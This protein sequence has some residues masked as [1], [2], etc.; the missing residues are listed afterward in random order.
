MVCMQGIT[1]TSSARSLY[2]QI[3][4]KPGYLSAQAINSVRYQV[5]HACKALP[6]QVV[7]DPG[8]LPIIQTRLP[9]CAGNKINSV[10]YQVWHACKALPAQVVQDPGMLAIKYKP[11]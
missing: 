10:R 6:A 9:A 2:L 5:W 7:Q 4:Y 11:G 8:M 3:H 1:C